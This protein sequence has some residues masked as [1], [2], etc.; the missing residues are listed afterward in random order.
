MPSTSAGNLSG[1]FAPVLTPFDRTLAPD[2]QSF[3]RFCRWL[4]SQ[5]VGLAVF[6]TNSEANSLSV[7]ERLDLLDTLIDAGL[8]AHRMMP[9]TGSCS[10]PDAV[11]LCAAAA[12]AKT[13]AVLMLP[14][15]YYKP[16][17]DDALFSFYAET[18][19]RVGDPHL[20]I[21]LYHIP[22]LSGVPIT[23]T[24]IEMLLRRYPGI[25]A[26]IKDSSGDFANTK[27]ML[28]RFEGFRVFCGS[29]RFLTETMRHD[30]AGCISA[31]A[32]V[33][34]SAI[35]DAYRRSSEPCADTRQQG[36][37]RLRDIFQDYPMI[38]ALK[39]AAAHFGDH[40]TFRII[41][42]PLLELNSEQGA[43]LIARLENAGFAMPGLTSA[44]AG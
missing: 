12:Q 29:E 22:Q 3:I 19:E 2:R 20:K 41:R 27:A 24:L 35:A 26:G 10:L 4:L 34:P 40:Q 9:G 15:F 13:A 6:G 38:A 8:P 18:I 42:P 28:D 11:R 33:N 17:S 14:P 31:C 39:H 7:D 25:I 37:D 43:S 21:C 32:N 5:G 30:G 36:L 1:V 44:L 23:L 16:V